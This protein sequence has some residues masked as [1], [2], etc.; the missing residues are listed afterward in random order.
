MEF[1]PHAKSFFSSLVWAL[2]PVITAS[3]VTYFIYDSAAWKWLLWV[4]DGFMALLSLFLL[5][6]NIY[7]HLQKIYLDDYC[8]KVSSPLCTTELKWQDIV[9]ALLRERINAM[10][11]TDHL[12]ILRSY[13]GHMLLFNTSTLDL[14]DEEIVL[15]KV[16]EKTDLKVQRDSPSL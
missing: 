4:A 16:R 9:D 3:I 13:G 12:L 6:Q 5:Q 14:K 7:V 15:K 1:K 8:I 2:S 11:G 10:S